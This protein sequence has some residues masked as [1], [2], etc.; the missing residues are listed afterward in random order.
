MKTY[1]ILID[2]C[3]SSCRSEWMSVHMR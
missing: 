2:R 3:K 1:I